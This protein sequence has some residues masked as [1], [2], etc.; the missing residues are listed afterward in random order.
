MFKLHWLAAGM[1]EVAERTK[2]KLVERAK[3]DELL[4]PLQPCLPSLPALVK[5][6]Q[7]MSNGFSMPLAHS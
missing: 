6:Q 1:S 2:L 4:C 5:G 3:G 7:F